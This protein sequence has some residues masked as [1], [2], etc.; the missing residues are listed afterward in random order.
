MT[1]HAGATILV[2]GAAGYIGRHLCRRLLSTGRKVV[3]FDQPGTASPDPGRFVCGDIRRSNDVEPLVRESDLVVHLACWPVG[4]CARDPEG[5]FAVNALGTS[6]VAQA[7]ARLARPL[8]FVSTSEVYGP[9]KILP[10]SEN[11]PTEPVSP[12]G[13][14]KLCGETVCRMWKRTANLRLIVPRLFSVYGPDL[15]GRPRPTVDT[16]FLSRVLRGDP[17]V[18]TSNPQTTRDFV[19]IED[20]IDALVLCIDHF[21]RAEGVS[22]N[23]AAG[24]GTSL[25][26]LAAIA[27]RLVGSA[28]TAGTMSE[29]SAAPPERYVADIS[30][31]AR[32]LGYQPR[33]PLEDGLEMVLASLT[34]TVRNA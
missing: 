12:Y 29:C 34:G 15:D 9:G 5:G 2:T 21:D 14:G 25:E 30:L 7:C 31:A 33:T 24:R 19:Y 10:M 26:Q 23:I 4:A 6:N 32:T 1:D 13:A 8:I 27:S 22:V 3:G 16:L 28:A 17:I 18:F 11:H 20:V